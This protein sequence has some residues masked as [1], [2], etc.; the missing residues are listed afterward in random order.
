MPPLW[1]A[2]LGV[3]KFI[4]PVPGD[5][6]EFLGCSTL[7]NIANCQNAL[8]PDT[9]ILYNHAFFRFPGS[10]RS[11]AIWAL[12]TTGTT[13]QLVTHLHLPRTFEAHT[14]YLGD[15]ALPVEQA[16]RIQRTE[17]GTRLKYEVTNVVW[18][19]R[20]PLDWSEGDEI[21]IFLV[22]PVWAS[23]LTVGDIHFGLGCGAPRTPSNAGVSCGSSDLSDTSIEFRNSV[24]VDYVNL[25]YEGMPGGQGPFPAPSGGSGLLRF[26]VDRYWADKE[27]LTLK[28][29]GKPFRVA[30]GVEHGCHYGTG[31][32]G[33]D[34][35]GD[36]WDS[37][38]D[39]AFN[40]RK[41]NKGHVVSWPHSGLDWSPGDTVL[42][43]LEYQKTAWYGA[44]ADSSIAYDVH[45]RER[46]ST[47]T[48]TY[49]YDPGDG[50]TR[51]VT[52]TLTGRDELRANV[53]LSQ[54]AP[55]GGRT[56]IPSAR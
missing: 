11:Y 44:Y 32:G 46:P 23:E 8:P 39:T 3:K 17:I 2:T 20:E 40:D 10:S 38:A 16:S 49:S 48:V 47:E 6:T 21:D 33:A 29:D 15:V 34:R 42:L 50:T 24:N 43:T 9:H 37:G 31:Y 7:G 53:R 25:R 19:L 35:T 5:D 51:T 22:P 4:S 27:F 13:F 1:S 26:A 45:F 55:P 30:D 41:S 36:C 28:V 12:R 52:S 54:P 18:Q 56:T 14:L